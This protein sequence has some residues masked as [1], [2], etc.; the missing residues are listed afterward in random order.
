MTIEQQI[1]QLQ[2]DVSEQTTA[3]DNLTQEVVGKMGAI[4]N[5]V[6]N[7]ISQMDAQ[8][9]Q[10]LTATRAEQIE[11]EGR[12]LHEIHIGGSPDLLYPVWWRFPNNSL[13]TGRLT[14]HRTYG[15]NGGGGSAAAAYRNISDYHIAALLLE[16]E[17]NACPWSGDANFLEIKRFHERYNG[18]VSHVRFGAYARRESRDGVNP[19]DYGSD[20]TNYLYSGC[21]LRGGGLTYRITKN[22]NA[23]IHFQDGSD[24]K[25]KNTLHEHDNSRFFVQPIPWTSRV[26]PV[27][28]TDAF[29]NKATA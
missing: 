18:T 23:D 6:N 2:Q 12:Y 10:W 8:V 26:A 5:Q 15:A 3:V 1:V 17:G 7:S 9:Q 11:G 4:N 20:G 25:A 13:G 24:P 22:W 28:D 14:I 19:P 29:V 27:E 21:Y 16:L